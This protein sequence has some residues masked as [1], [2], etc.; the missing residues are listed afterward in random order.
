MAGRPWRRALATAGD[1]QAAAGELRGGAQQRA[2]AAGA[3]AHPKRGRGGRPSR[4]GIELPPRAEPES[5]GA[6]G[7]D[8]LPVGERLVTSLFADVRG[9]SELT[10]RAAPADLA[11]RMSALY[12]FA[13]VAVNRHEGV[14]DK[15]AG[16][17]VMATFNV[18]GT[19]V[20][21]CVDAVEAAMALRDRA[22]L[23]GLPMGSASPPGRRCWGADRH[24]RT[25][26]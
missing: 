4:S 6:A 22:A 20:D 8:V 13:K 23:M 21:H 10:A 26:R 24:A 1:R 3:A 17:A 14:V 19:R 18:T 11:D 7:P 12:R 25:S 9:Y 2:D 5:A 15:F 16:D